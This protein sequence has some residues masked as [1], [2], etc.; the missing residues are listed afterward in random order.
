MLKVVIGEV[1]FF[2]KLV[3]WQYFLI[4][5]QVYRQFNFYFM[6]KMGEVLGIMDELG[7]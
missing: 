3:F 1:F 7:Y 5:V 6:F 2:K 4:L